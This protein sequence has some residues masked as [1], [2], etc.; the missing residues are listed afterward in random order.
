MK[1]QIDNSI[2]LSKI[3][4]KIN[5]SKTKNRI[6][7][8]DFLQ[9]SELSMVKKY[10]MQNHI[11]YYFYFGGIEN[12]DRQCICFYPDKLDKDMAIK[13]IKN[14]MDV[15]H[16]ILPNE[17]KYTHGEYLSG[18]MKIGLVREKFGD[19]VVRTDD[20][21]GYNGA[22][23]ICFKSISKII[24]D[25]IPFLTRFKKAKI[26]QITIDQIQPKIEQFEFIKIIVASNRLDN[27][28]SELAHCS[29]TNAQ[30]YLK[31]G[32][33]FINGI[34]EFKDSKK[35]SVGD[36]VTIRGK[37]KFIFDSIIGETKNNRLNILIKKYK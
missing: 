12:A 33:V 31:L 10:I 35:L 26:S 13:S 22:D 5:E 4:D 19:I 30:E 8:S 1:D 36:T 3:D 28:V 25:N 2:L 18:L 21:D 20:V 32:K 15:I 9:L 34:N 29:R 27:F 11:K 37:G 23:I 16:I 17:L 7:Y 6:T 14:E 24:L